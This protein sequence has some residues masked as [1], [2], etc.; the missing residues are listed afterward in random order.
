MLAVRRRMALAR[1]RRP[2]RLGRG[3]RCMPPLT[4]LL[5]TR[6]QPACM[7]FFRQ[8]AQSSLASRAEMAVFGCVWRVL[9]LVSDLLRSRPFL[10]RPPAVWS[11][12]PPLQHFRPLKTALLGMVFSS[13]FYWRGYLKSLKAESAP[14]LFLT[15]FLMPLRHQEGS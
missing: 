4:Y 13:R 11:A 9:V 15:S 7:T 10:A 14:P 3:G 12:G 1:S 5:P 6:W 2:L 8:L